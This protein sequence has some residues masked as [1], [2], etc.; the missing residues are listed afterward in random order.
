MN[1]EAKILKIKGEYFNIGSKL[2]Y[3]K[4]SLL[5]ATKSIYKDEIKN[6]INKL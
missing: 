3:L 1:G 6:Y 5:F 2:G 4:A